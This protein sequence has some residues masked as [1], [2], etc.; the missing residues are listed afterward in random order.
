M[1]LTITIHLNSEHPDTKW[2]TST[3]FKVEKELPC[4]LA[5]QH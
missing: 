5:A 2:I 1:I 4:Y 3:R